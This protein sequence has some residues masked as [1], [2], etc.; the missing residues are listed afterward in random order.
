MQSEAQSSPCNAT[1]TQM[2]GALIPFVDLATLQELTLTLRLTLTY[3]DIA[4]NTEDN[5]AIQTV[6]DTNTDNNTGADPIRFQK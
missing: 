2:H 3:T 6:F 1:E 4:D 5:A